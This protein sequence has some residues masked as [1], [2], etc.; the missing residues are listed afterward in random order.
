[1]KQLKYNAWVRSGNTNSGVTCSIR[2]HIL[3]EI[4]SRVFISMYNT[5]RGR[6]YQLDLSGARTALFIPI[7]KILKNE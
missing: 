1:M 2:H 5:L 7:E 4:N 6:I 3:R